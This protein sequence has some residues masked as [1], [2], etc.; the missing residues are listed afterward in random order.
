MCLIIFSSNSFLLSTIT[1]RNNYFNE[2]DRLH[3]L[4]FVRKYEWLIC[5][6]ETSTTLKGFDEVVLNKI[7]Y[8]R[9]YIYTH[10]E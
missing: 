6:L 7:F 2:K 9:A 8:V 4:K 10:M 1:M 5:G 3:D